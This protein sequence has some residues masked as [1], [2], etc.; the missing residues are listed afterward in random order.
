MWM[1]YIHS[2]F[3]DIAHQLGLPGMGHYMRREDIAADY[4]RRTGYAPRDLD[5]YSLYSALR[6]GTVS[7]RVQQ[8][9]V[10]FGQAEPPD[11]P[12]DMVMHRTAI[13]SMLAGTYW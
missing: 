5:W 3:D 6:Y 1:A 8:R 4:D 13:E 10:H 11:D 7:V 12:D 9:S 2:F